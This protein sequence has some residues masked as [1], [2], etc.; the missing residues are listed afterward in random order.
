MNDQEL[1]DGARSFI[2]CYDDMTEM[3]WRFPPEIVIAAL[4]AEIKELKEALNN[5][6]ALHGNSR[7]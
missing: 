5:G 4:V 6:E 2:D 7:R 1:I 3:W